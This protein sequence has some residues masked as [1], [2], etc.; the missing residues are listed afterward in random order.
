[1]LK[2]FTPLMLNNA[3]FCC[4]VWIPWIPYV[5]NSPVLH[6]MW[7][8]SVIKAWFIQNTRLC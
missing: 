6:I 3:K 5:V 4:I 1:M 7:I 2:D 8:L